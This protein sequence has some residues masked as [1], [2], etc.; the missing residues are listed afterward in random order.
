MELL[1]SSSK[2]VLRPQAPGVLTRAIAS[3]IGTVEETAPSAVRRAAPVL[4]A[5]ELRGARMAEDWPLRSHLELGAFPGAVPC[6]RL[7]AKQVLWEWGLA[8][9]IESAELL[10]SELATNALKASQALGSAAT[11]HLWLLSDKTRAL[12]LVWDR[13]PRPPVRSDATDEDEGGRGLLLVES[14][15]ETWGWYFP[16]H[17]GGK[18]VWCRVSR[19]PKRAQEPTSLG[20]AADFM[21]ERA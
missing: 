4:P 21:Q 12:I 16:A 10:V 7:H 11:I 17:L 6:A 18:V 5:Q 9:L 15:S 2:A 3:E 14:V 8:E 13:N 1:M 20:G 19:L